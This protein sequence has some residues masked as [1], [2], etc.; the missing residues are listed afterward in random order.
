MKTN[1]MREL[2]MYRTRE[3][4]CQTYFEC[5]DFCH[6]H[7]QSWLCAKRMDGC[8]VMRDR[9]DAPAGHGVTSIEPRPAAK[10][11]Q[12]Y[13]QAELDAEAML[14]KRN[15]KKHVTVNAIIRVGLAVERLSRS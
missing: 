2:R 8:E 5:Y 12:F 9:A 13:R 11:A 14:G 6:T 4:C 15:S 7:A 10:R 1:V 3:L